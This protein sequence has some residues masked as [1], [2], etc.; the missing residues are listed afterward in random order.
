MGRYKT[1][2]LR[3][4]RDTSHCS[5]CVHYGGCSLWLS[6]LLMNEEPNASGLDCIIPDITKPCPMFFSWMEV[7]AQKYRSELKAAGR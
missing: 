1:A 6:L 3:R 2:E 7:D 4:F 5:A